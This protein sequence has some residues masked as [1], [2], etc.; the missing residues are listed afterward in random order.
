MNPQEQLC[1]NPQ[2]AAS[3]KTGQIRIHSRKEQRYR[4]KSCGRTFSAS[5]GTAYYRV[6]KAHGLLTLVVTLLAYGCPVQAIV[7]AFGLDERT[8]WAWLQRAGKHGQV[9]H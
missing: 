5:Y 7:M 1:P 8:V 9:V 6:K 2:C 3:G 4:C